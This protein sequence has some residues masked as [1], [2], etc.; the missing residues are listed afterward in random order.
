MRVAL[1]MGPPDAQTDLTS[2]KCPIGCVRSPESRIA[3]TRRMTSPTLRNLGF[4][5]LG[6]Q[7]LTA[8]AE[9]LI[10]P[11]V[12]VLAYHDV[13]DR[14]QLKA[15][16]KELTRRRT[17]VSAED[18][19]ACLSGSQRWPTRPVLIT[20]DDGDPSVLDDGLPVLEDLGIPAILFVVASLVDT[21]LPF[22]WEEVEALAL[23]GIRPTGHESASPHSLV[24]TLKGIPNEERLRIIDTMRK[25]HGASSPP[26]RQLSSEELRRLQSAG[27]AI[28][29]HTM[30][31]PCLDRCTRDEVASELTNAHAHLTAIL[32]S[33][34][35]FFAYP[36]GNH[37]GSTAGVLSDLGYLGAFLF[38]HRT[39]TTAPEDCFAISR[40][41]VNASDSI[42]EFRAKISGLHPLLYG[43]RR[44]VITAIP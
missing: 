26:R 36:N 4:R 13:P 38:D 2:T 34:P 10:R 42:P 30:S 31:H 14:S 6:S 5:A 23:A 24:D 35:R 16:L 8:L 39:S 15:Q 7:G 17:P 9:S 18:Y 33:P 3:T 41:R 27:I 19:G 37:E 1:P 44:R 29:N 40:V 11:P 43:L 22:W 28:G 12:L 25:D 20:F 21:S 32:G